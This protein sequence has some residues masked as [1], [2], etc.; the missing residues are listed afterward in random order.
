MLQLTGLYAEIL[1]M[2]D[3][4]TDRLHR[5]LCSVGNAEFLKQRFR[6]GFRGFLADA[7]FSGDFLVALAI[8]NKAQNFEFA[9][10]KVFPH[11]PL[12]KS[13]GDVWWHHRFAP[14]GCFDRMNQLGARKALE[15][16]TARSGLNRT[17]DVLIAIKSRDDQHARGGP[18][19]A[20]RQ[21]R[22][23]A[24]TA[25]NSQVHEN[26]V[27][28]VFCAGGEGTG[29]VGGFGNNVQMS[30]GRQHPG[31]SDAEGWVVIDDENADCFRHVV[32]KVR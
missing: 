11:H 13:N 7:E 9:G 28:F 5:R 12:A 20:N 21:R 24:T 18:A 26:Y 27:G 22:V 25:R 2:N 10:R 16:I 8:D 32:Q 3:A 19:L 4:V 14:M 1:E 15:Q 31:Q 23:H 30:M 29:V 17:M 6:V